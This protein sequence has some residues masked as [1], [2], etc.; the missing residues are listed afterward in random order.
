LNFPQSIATWVN[1]HLELWQFF[2][3]FLKNIQSKEITTEKQ[4]QANLKPK[5]R[6][7]PSTLV[8]IHPEFKDYEW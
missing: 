2:I 6:Q 8:L 1:V 5:S 4:I 7:T 3:L